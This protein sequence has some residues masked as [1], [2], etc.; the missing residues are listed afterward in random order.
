MAPNAIDKVRSLTLTKPA[1]RSATAAK[2][3]EESLRRLGADDGTLAA[4]S[5]LARS[6]R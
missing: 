2:R 4:V 3:L 1:V 5:G 6:I